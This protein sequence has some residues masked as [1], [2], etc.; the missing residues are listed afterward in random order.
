MKTP[1]KKLWDQ[2]IG[3]DYD[4]YYDKAGQYRFPF[5][6][7]FGP[8][9]KIAFQL[10]GHDFDRTWTMTPAQIESI[11]RNIIGPPTLTKGTYKS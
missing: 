11:L 5:T 7:E 2:L 8:T 1:I 3:F 10:I 4:K 6:F 9:R